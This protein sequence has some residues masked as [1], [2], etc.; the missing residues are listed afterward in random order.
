MNGE[1]IFQM[2]TLDQGFSPDGNYAYA[3]DEALIYD[4]IA[5][6]KL[7]FNT[8]RKHVKMESRRWYYHTD[9]L[10][11]L[12]WQDLPSRDLNG[13]IP[14]EYELWLEEMT[15]AI[16][17]RKNAASII[18]WVTFNE[19]WGQSASNNPN[20]TRETVKMVQTL[21]PTR[22]VTDASGG[23][24]VCNS[25][26]GDRAHFWTGG[27]YG[28]ITDVHHYSLP[29]QQ[30]EHLQ[31]VTRDCDPNKALVLGEYG[32]VLLVPRG[33]EW[34][35]SKSHGYSAAHTRRELEQIY[36]QYAEKLVEA[37]DLYGISAAVYTQITDVETECNGFLTYDRIFKVHPTAIAYSNKKVIQ[38]FSRKHSPSSTTI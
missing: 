36:D 29:A 12:V 18:Q 6:K 1:P 24:N 16:Q 14:G 9:R 26:N 25:S 21:D 33:H 38:H 17:I 34:L 35:P 8:I 30:L 22:L 28:D 13:N 5:T 15:N 3:T 32:G 4:L 19:G 23:R 2:A 10:G 37:I 11:I 7:G 27:C 20:I 31:N